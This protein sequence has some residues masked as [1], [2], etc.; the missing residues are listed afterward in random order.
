MNPNTL[1]R[2]LM[3]R[4]F[5]CLFILILAALAAYAGWAG[6]KGGAESRSAVVVV[7]PW[8][9]IDENFKNPMLN[10]TDRATALATALVV[11]IQRGDVQGAVV[12]AGAT[13]Y[14]ASNLSTDARDP[15]RSAVIFLT[16]TGP[17]KE[18]A[19]AGALSVIDGTRAVL[20]G[21]QEDAGTGDPSFMA[22]LQVISPPQETTTFAARQVRSAAAFGAAVLIGGILIFWAIESML[23]RRSRLRGR[24][25]PAPL[26]SLV[27]DRRKGGD[28]H[29]LNSNSENASEIA[30]PTPRDSENAPHHS[31]NAPQLD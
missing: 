14:D 18:A 29:E 1:V 19:H 28:W 24:G 25:I 13:S 10:L 12:N 15:T 21:M 16:V 27:V 20:T 8:S 23:D 26:E 9:F 6:A 4:P 31:E 17:N 11:A 22:Q 7:P 3:Q 2:R 5:V 30:G